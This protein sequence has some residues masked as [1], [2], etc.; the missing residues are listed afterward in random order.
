[1][2][3]FLCAILYSDD[4]EI[5]TPIRARDIDAEQYPI[6]YTTLISF[7][8]IPLQNPSRI[9]ISSHKDSHEFLRPPPRIGPAN[10]GRCIDVAS[11][12]ICWGNMVK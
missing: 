1:M 10:E 6:Y 8:S 11:M 4:S 12:S 3:I 2:V 5:F 7:E 9:A